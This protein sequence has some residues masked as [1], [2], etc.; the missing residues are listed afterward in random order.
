[1][2]ISPDQLRRLA[3]FF[4]EDDLEW[5]IGST[6]RDNKKG[7]ALV[8]VTNRAIM[9]RLDDVCGPGNW[10]NQYMSGPGGGVLCGLSILVDRGDPDRGGEWVTKWDGAENTDYEG[11]KGGLSG[12]MKR[13]AVQWG[14]GRYL[15]EMPQQWVELDDRKRMKRSPR[16]PANFLPQAAPRQQTP[17]KEKP[18]VQIGARIEDAM[19]AVGNGLGPNNETAAFHQWIDAQGFPSDAIAWGKKTLAD[20]IADVL[21]PKG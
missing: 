1:M 15:Y 7:M 2:Y 9:A 18:S 16:V 19:R 20:S 14:I 13:A 11:V 6:T 12:S 4:P 8:Y 10:Q 3:D 21:A 5:R 17:K